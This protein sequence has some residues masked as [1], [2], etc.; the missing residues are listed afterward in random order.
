MGLILLWGAF[1]GLWGNLLLKTK[2]IR[3]NDVAA[4][5]GVT[6]L[7][8][9]GGPKKD[10]I[11]TVAGTGAGFLSHNDTRVHFELAVSG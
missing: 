6:L 9:S 2:P 10:L 1:I 5:A 11:L 8:V 7:I 3:L 4:E